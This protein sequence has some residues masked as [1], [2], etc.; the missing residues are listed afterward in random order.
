VPQFRNQIQLD[1]HINKLYTEILKDTSKSQNKL[2]Y[3]DLGEG[4]GV[5]NDKNDTHFPC[6]L[7]YH[8]SLPIGS[9]LKLPFQTMLNTNL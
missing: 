8:G 2:G 5:R 1:A 6:L 9:S 4:Q 7:A 3:L